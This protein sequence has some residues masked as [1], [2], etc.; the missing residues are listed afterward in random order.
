MIITKIDFS[1]PRELRY[2]SP[3]LAKIV[4]P[5]TDVATLGVVFAATL[6]D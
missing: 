1:P 2:A 3:N 6:V 4:S 5:W